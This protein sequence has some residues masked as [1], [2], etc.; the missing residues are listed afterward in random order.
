MNITVK[1]TI[2]DN[3][4]PGI[5]ATFPGAVSAVVKKTAMDVEA[6]AKTLCP[7]VYWSVEAQYSGGS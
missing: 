3:R 1:T 2:T 6:E 5:M 7:V 4:I